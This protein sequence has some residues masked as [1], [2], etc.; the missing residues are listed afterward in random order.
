MATLSRA[1]PGGGGGGGTYTIDGDDVM[2]E[3]TP[4]DE[5]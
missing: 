2:V 1:E 4:W 5:L 3:F